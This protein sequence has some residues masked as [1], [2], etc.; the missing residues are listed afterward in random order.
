M[1]LSA[2]GDGFAGA[3]AAGGGSAGAA[4]GGGGAAA[5]AQPP[6]ALRPPAPP[7][8]AASPNGAGDD[9]V[10]IGLSLAEDMTVNPCPL[11]HT[12]STTALHI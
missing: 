10:G 9:V 7:L 1:K 6:Q 8:A 11:P 3:A 4:V 5:V 12:P 2:D